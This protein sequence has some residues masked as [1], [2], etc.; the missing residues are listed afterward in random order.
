MKGRYSDIAAGGGMLA[1]GS[2]APAR[3]GKAE[4]QGGR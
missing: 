4:R 2:A 3:R 1:G